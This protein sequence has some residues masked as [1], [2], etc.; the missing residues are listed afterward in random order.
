LLNYFRKSDSDAPMKEYIMGRFD[1]SDDKW[2]IIEPHFPKPGAGLHVRMTAGFLMA[3]FIFCARVLL[4]AT[5]RSVMG[6]E[7]RFITATTDGANAVSGRTSLMHSP[8]SEK[9]A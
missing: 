9:T 2:G 1:L 6:L 4:G 7:Q 8:M 5:S 3:S